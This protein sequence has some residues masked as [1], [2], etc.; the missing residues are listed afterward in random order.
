[1]L[2]ILI[3]LLRF[4]PLIVRLA[5]AAEALGTNPNSATEEV[6]MLISRGERYEVAMRLAALIALV[7]AYGGPAEIKRFGLVNNADR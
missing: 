5:G 7:L 3:V 2:A 4:V 6:R 1:M